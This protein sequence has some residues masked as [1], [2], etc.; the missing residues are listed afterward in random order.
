MSGKDEAYGEFLKDLGALDDFLD[1][2]NVPAASGSPATGGTPSGGDIDRQRQRAIALSRYDPDVRRLLEAVAFFSS[3]TRR[4]AVAGL[5]K[6]FD[7]VNA[8]NLDFLLTAMPAMTTV[9]VSGKSVASLK[10]GIPALPAGTEL[11]I[12]TPSN[13]VGYFSTTRPLKIWPLTATTK[14]GQ[15][16]T[17]WPDRLDG[18]GFRLTVTVESGAVNTVKDLVDRLSFHIDYRDDYARSRRLA[19]LLEHGLKVSV[20]F[21]ADAVARPCQARVGPP[22]TTDAPEL[23]ELAHPLDRV[24]SFFHLPSQDLFLNVTLPDSPSTWKKATFFL[25]GE[26]NWPDDLY[27]TQDTFQLFVVPVVNLRMAPATPIVCDGTKESYPIRA[28]NPAALGTGLDL[29]GEEARLHS[30]AGVYRLTARGFAPLQSALLARGEWAYEIDVEGSDPDRLSHRLLLQCPS[31]FGKPETISVDARWYQPAFDTIATGQLRVELQKIRL[32]GAFFALG[33]NLQ[34]HRPSPYFGDP[35]RLLHVLGLR[36]EKL[37]GKDDLMSLLA[38]LGLDAQSEHAAVIGWVAGITAREV[39]ET[40]LARG[41]MR[42]VYE[43]AMQPY[44][45]EAQGLVDDFARQ[46]HAMLRAWLPCGVEVRV[47]QQTAETARLPA[48]GAS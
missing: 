5:R 9:R 30:V 48:G 8:G 4:L 17:G 33:Q 15:K 24:R 47:S 19:G 36:T 35:L 22:T 10:F 32:E 6:A 37:L 38:G 44:P 18:G 16:G 34:A 12:T 39:P 46:L 21:D 14:V 25:E 20:K 31:A 27:V 23:D 41:G 43:V 45:L 11:R 2:S 7:R 13:A 29:K 42:L 40:G 26:Q 3:R 1:R 28:G